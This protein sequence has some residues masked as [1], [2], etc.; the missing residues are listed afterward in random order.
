MGRPR[1]LGSSAYL[2]HTVLV[3]SKSSSVRSL[4]ND[5]GIFIWIRMQPKPVR[6]QTIIVTIA[7]TMMAMSV[8]PAQCAESAYQ[9]T[10]QTDQVTFDKKKVQG[11]MVTTG[12]IVTAATPAQVWAS[13][14]EEPQHDTNLKSSKILSRQDSKTIV[15]QEFQGVPLVGETHCIVETDANPGRSLSY[16]LLSSNHFKAL[17]A[18]WTITTCKAT[19]RTIIE[20]KCHVETKVFCPQMLLEH[21]VAQRIKRRL[22]F[23]KAWAETPADTIAYQGA[24]HDDR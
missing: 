13:I 10:K 24:A 6:Y 22:E 19:N 4:N 20:L 15:E 11:Q 17:E 9:K 2:L 23:V 3:S 8:I 14:L 21:V 18:A 7:L 16:K 1:I 5:A 12:R